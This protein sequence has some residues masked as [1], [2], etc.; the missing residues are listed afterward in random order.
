MYHELNHFIP[1]AFLVLIA[2]YG[3]ARGAVIAASTLH[4]NLLENILKLPMSF[5]DTTPL[6]R[7]VNRFSKDIDTVDSTIPQTIRYEYSSST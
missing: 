4:K 7:I 6:G 1:T 3:M 2:A 5:F